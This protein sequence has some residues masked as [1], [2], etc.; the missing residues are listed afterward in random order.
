MPKAV[1]Y[2]GYCGFKSLA[3]VNP[4]F[5]KYFTIR[6]IPNY[7]QNGN[8][9]KT[10]SARSMRYGTNS[11]LFRACLVWNKLPVSIK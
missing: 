2:I 8:I 11:I 7:F 4:D 1:T 6:E 3:D 5:M 9:L 10:F